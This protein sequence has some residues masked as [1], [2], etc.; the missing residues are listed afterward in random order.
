MDC[1]C[2]GIQKLKQK[3]LQQKCCQMKTE[4][5]YIPIQEQIFVMKQFIFLIVTRFYDGDSSNNART[6][7]DAKSTES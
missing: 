2:L 7:E 6:S 1:R 3:R 5:L 4:E